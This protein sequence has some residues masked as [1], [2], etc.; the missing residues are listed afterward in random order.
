MLPNMAAAGPMCLLN[1]WNAASV[2]EELGFHLHF[3]TGPC[4][5]GGLTLQL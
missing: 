2:A 4:E 1:A 3:I 5:A